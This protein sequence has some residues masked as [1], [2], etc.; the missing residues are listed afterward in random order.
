MKR[1]YLI[2][3]PIAVFI[4]CS[5]MVFALQTLRLHNYSYIKQMFLISE[6]QHLIHI[7]SYS[8]FARLYKFSLNFSQCLFLNPTFF[9]QSRL[10][11]FSIA[12]WKVFYIE[13]RY[14]QCW[15]TCGFGYRRSKWRCLCIHAPTIRKS[16][17]HSREL[18]YSGDWHKAL[19][20]T[21]YPREKLSSTVFRSHWIV[22]SLSLFV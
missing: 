17:V 10:F 13:E 4:F 1:L 11:N 7:L 14:T 2:Y 22:V 18:F 21:K 9:T 16:Y 5:T 12:R 19:Q 8:H 6:K 3:T 20:T 15:Y